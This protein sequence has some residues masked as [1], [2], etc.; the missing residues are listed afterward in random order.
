MLLAIVKEE[1]GDPE[2]QVTFVVDQLLLLVSA[3]VLV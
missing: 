2:A 3:T 1:Q